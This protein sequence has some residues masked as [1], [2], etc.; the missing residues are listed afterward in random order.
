MNKKPAK[1]RL[2]FWLCGT[3]K[4]RVDII[5]IGQEIE[6]AKDKPPKNWNAHETLI[7][8]NK[9]RAHGFPRAFALRGNRNNFGALSLPKSTCFRTGRLRDV[10]TTRGPRTKNKTGI[11]PV[12]FLVGAHGFEP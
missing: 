7:N 5:K 2:N 12:E 8:N 11:K 3:G 10:A 6:E 4:T 1:C 9:N